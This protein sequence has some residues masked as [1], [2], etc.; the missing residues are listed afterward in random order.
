MDEFLM[1]V[2]ITAASTIV[3]EPVKHIINTWLKPKLESI[4]MQNE[5][6][7][8]L[9]T[10]IFEVF[11]DYITKTFEEQSS[12]NIIALGL[13]QIKIN[14]I[15]VPLTLHSEERRESVILNNFP[16]E[17]AN[18]YKKI[19]IE[20]TAGMGKSTLMRQMFISAI[21]NNLGIPIFIELRNLSGDKDIIDY[22]VEN[23]NKI[24]TEHS[25][26]FILEVINRGDFI[27][28]LDGYDEIPFQQKQAVTKNLKQFVSN[29]NDNIFFLTS[30]PDD[31]LMSFGQFQKFEI[32][33][34]KKEEAFELI[35]KC[36][37][38]TG[39]N[40][41]E[42]IINQIIESTEDGDFSTLETF[43]ANPMLVSFL[44]ITFKHKKDIP[45]L[46][47]DLYRKVF[48]ALYEL[49]DLSKD[50]YKREKYSG[51]SSGNL[52]KILMKL[53]FLCLRENENDYDKGK[54][55]KLISQAKNSPYFHEIQE[56]NILKDLLET[57]PLFSKIGLGYKWAHKSFMDYFAA[58]FID[59]QE[60]REKILI[61]IYNSRNFT[62]YLN[63]IDFYYE[64]DRQ[65]FDKVFV[66]PIINQF[67]NFVDASGI[68]P[69]EQRVQLEYLEMIFNRIFIFNT[70]ILKFGRKVSFKEKLDSIVGLYKNSMP[71]VKNYK[72][73]RASEGSMGSYL[74]VKETRIENIFRLLMSKK[75]VL[76]KHVNGDGVSIIEEST[77]FSWE[78]TKIDQ[79]SDYELQLRMSLV[80]KTFGERRTAGR[81]KSRALFT[82][83]YFEALKY[84]ELVE[85][86]IKNREETL[87]LNL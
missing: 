52:Q 21:E 3:V 87:F 55:I 4:K 34:L 37:E 72:L 5:I 45:S 11:A 83:D 76:L 12:V 61:D 63:M 82:L 73:L 41:S 58:N 26:E 46:K 51:L 20:D 23:L 68:N 24:R 50:S 64:I 49:H 54:I 16:N 28:F 86:E 32:L 40:L 71:Y 17:F 78:Q 19:V 1:K 35:T 70:D 69:S 66:Y 47:I 56:E 22:I 43:L 44:Y 74:L 27:F 29:A 8:K 79:I 31:S 38:I 65:L 77:A 30:R 6:N 67:I 48:D 60:T 39:L 33:D 7:E 75:S 85:E 13:Q 62:L 42:K 59:Y 36:D 25:K 2:S 14:Q 9:E 57:V 53:G 81:Y 10:F 18:K 15:Y 80:K 84:K